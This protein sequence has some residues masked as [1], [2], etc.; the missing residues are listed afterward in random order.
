MIPDAPGVTTIH[1][2]HAWGKAATR[3]L[4]SDRSELHPRFMRSSLIACALCLIQVSCQPPAP[5]AIPTSAPEAT[6]GPK[7]APAADASTPARTKP[8]PVRKGK[9]T[10]ISLDQVFALQSE[11]RVL[12]VDVRRPIMF[13]LG[14]VDGAINLPLSSF[15]S[16]LEKH[17][18]TLDAAV[19]SN[20][21]IVLY[22]DGENC[23]DAHNTA[24]AL[25]RH[26]YSTSV[27]RGGWAEWKEVGL[28]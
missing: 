22:C 28:P 10:Q 23:P 2:P 24:L 26:G 4:E 20:K 3:R 12:M 6:P 11:G 15:E 14:H 18:G 5:E 19:N 27:Y 16:S 9:V 25:A 21:V 1:L 7:P 8:E 13:A 17:R